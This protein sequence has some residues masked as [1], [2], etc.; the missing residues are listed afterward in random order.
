MHSK[1]SIPQPFS[2][3]KLTSNVWS[4]HGCLDTNWNNP[5]A[6]Y[7]KSMPT[8]YSV[9]YSL[10]SGMCSL[11]PHWALSLEGKSLQSLEVC[12]P[13]TYLLFLRW[14]IWPLTLNFWC[15]EKFVQASSLEGDAICKHRAASWYE[16][17]H[18]TVNPCEHFHVYSSVCPETRISLLPFFALLL[19]SHKISV[20]MYFGCSTI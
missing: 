2:L 15:C 17:L 18:M 12:K 3:L 9:L 8:I 10:L 4:R 19:C 16:E 6:S 20:T 14:R 5:A 7:F 11:S 1:T 13:T